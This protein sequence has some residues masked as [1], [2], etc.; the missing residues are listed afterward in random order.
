MDPLAA[1]GFGPF[2]PEWIGP[3]WARLEAP[4]LAVIGSEPDSWG[5]LPES[6][7][8]ERLSHVRLL[9]RATVQGT[10]HFIHME[11]PLE[12]AELLLG[13]LAA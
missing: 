6:L 2:K 13:W 10:G 11:R 7:L 8:E 4:L 1:G 3:G 12:T 9:E 5:P